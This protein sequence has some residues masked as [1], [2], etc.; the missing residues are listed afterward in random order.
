MIVSHDE[1]ILDKT[2]ILERFRK[3]VGC[4]ADN[5]A[6]MTHHPEGFFRTGSS[7]GPALSW[8]RFD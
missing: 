1:I 3:E 4:L 2:D 7:H 5:L 8:G 6:A